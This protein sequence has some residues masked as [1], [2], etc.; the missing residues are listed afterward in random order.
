[1]YNC[2]ARIS[3]FVTVQFIFEEMLLCA[4]EIYS[5]VNNSLSCYLKHRVAQSVRCDI[6]CA[7]T[8]YGH[9]YTR[10]HNYWGDIDIA[11]ARRTG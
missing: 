3:F 11:H 2:L 1:M 7:Y 8:N 6:L 9:Y 4:V 5:T 10:A